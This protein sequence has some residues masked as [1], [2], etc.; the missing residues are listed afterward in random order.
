[1]A[2]VW[3][4]RLSARLIQRSGVQGPPG[5]VS[6]VNGPGCPS[7]KEPNAKRDDLHELE[8][9]ERWDDDHD[10]V[11]PPATSPR[12]VVPVA[13]TTEDFGPLAEAGRRRGLSTAAYIAAIALKGVADEVIAETWSSLRPGRSY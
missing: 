5:P 10:E 4:Y 7:P 6:R 12:V 8:D 9:A 2:G 3:Q 1:M 11:L 13:F